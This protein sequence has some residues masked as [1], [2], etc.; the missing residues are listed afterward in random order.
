MRAWR[1]LLGCAAAALLLVGASAASAS[2]SAPAATEE[3]TGGA[4]TP[5]RFD[6]LGGFHMALMEET[7]L[8]AALTA[9]GHPGFVLGPSGA[10]G[11]SYDL[12]SWLRIGGRVDVRYA[13]LERDNHLPNVLRPSDRGVPG[14]M[15]RA[16]PLFV[17]EARACLSGASCYG[18]EAAEMGLQLAAG[19]GAT[20]LRIR[21]EAD[22]AAH[23]VVEGALVMRVWIEDVGVGARLGHAGV[24]LADFPAS[25]LGHGFVWSPTVGLYMG[26]RW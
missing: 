15:W 17:A 2:A 24:Y 5:W 4:P 6:F 3:A 21:G 25:G 26:H 1:R 8:G 10:L 20:F 23:V 14:S 12:L 11:V 16:T 19:V 13:D 22:A 7:E 18:R 9:Y